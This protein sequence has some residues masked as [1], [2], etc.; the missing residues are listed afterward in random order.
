[1]DF[2]EVTGGRMLKRPAREPQNW[3]KA[4]RL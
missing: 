4:H 2:F 3:R 1:M